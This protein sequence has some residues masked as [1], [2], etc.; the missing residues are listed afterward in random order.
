L[1]SKGNCRTID[2]SSGWT[3]KDARCSIIFMPPSKRGAGW[4]ATASGYCQSR[5][6]ISRRSRSRFI[7]F[8]LGSCVNGRSSNARKQKD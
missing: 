7:D 5:M 6:L 8:G 2:P 1:S 4:R 3:S